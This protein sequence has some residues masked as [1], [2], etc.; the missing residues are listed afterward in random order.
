MAVPTLSWS[1]SPLILLLTLALPGALTAA[2]GTSSLTCFYNSRANVSCVLNQTRGLQASSCKIYAKSNQRPWIKTCELKQLARPDSWICNLILSENNDSQSLTAADILNLTLMCDHEGPSRMVLTQLF[3]PFRNIRL[4]APTSFQVTHIEPRRCNVTWKVPLS[5]HYLQ[6]TLEFEVRL[7]C[8]GQS[9]EEVSL[10]Q[11]KQNQQWIFLETLTPD[12]PYELQ[13]H[14]KSSRYVIWSHWSQPLAFRTRPEAAP[15]KEIPAYTWFPHVMVGLGISLCFVF[16]VSLLANCHYIGPWLKKALKCHIPD[17]SE[18]FAKL[19]SE[20]GGDFQKWLSSP[21]PSSSFSP[22]GQVP[23][24]SPLEVLDRDTKPMQLLW[25]QQDKVPSPSPSGHS[26]TSCFTNQGYFFFHLPDALEIESCQVYFTYDPCTELDE[27]RPETP[28]GSPLPPLPHL[29][30][31]DDAYCTF[32]PG[33]DLLLFSPSL[34]GGP[35]PLPIVP[36]CTGAGEEN[37]PPSLQAGVPRHWVPQPLGPLN[38][39]TPD[40]VDF[41]SPLGPALGD[42]ED[43]VPAPDSGER[44]GF[45]WVSPPRQG[46]LRVPTSCLTLNTDAYLSLQELQDQDPAHSA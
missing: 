20:H 24:I 16:L 1:L 9:W 19:S 6:D 31:E 11:I 26:L 39:G 15:G 40:L 43:E 7:R 8:P 2:N 30:G 42:T 36:E 21:F 14:V 3:D 17:P 27:G 35:V 13:V 29:P 10:M 34:I 4:M 28:E 5:S 37:L 41:H 33:E 23:E 32:P 44:P 18:F 25:L 12:T 46:E 38:P 22:N 45:P